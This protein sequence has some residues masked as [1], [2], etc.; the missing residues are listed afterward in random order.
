MKIGLYGGTFDPPHNAHL[1]LASWVRK[2]L[3]LEY[4][5][6]IPAAIHAFKNNERV[7]PP[8]VRVNLVERAIKNYA[9]FRISRIEVERKEISYTIHTLQRFRQYE[10]LPDCELYYIMGYDNLADFHLWKDPE[11]IMRLAKIV[12]IRRSVQ[13]KR[14]IRTEIDQNVIYL[15]S[16]LIDLSATEIR[17]KIKSGSDVSKLVPSSVLESIREYGLYVNQ[18]TG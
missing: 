10:N 11:K 12:V 3:D 4:I 6:F 7:S 1:E 13:E 15:N 17:N 9:H 18:S 8:S 14:P 5:Y 16:P 2:E